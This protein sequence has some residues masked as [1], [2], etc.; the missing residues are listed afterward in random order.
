MRMY[1]LFLFPPFEEGHLM[2]PYYHL[3]MTYI[4]LPVARKHVFKIVYKFIQQRNSVSA[5]EMKIST[6]NRK[7]EYVYFQSLLK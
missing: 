4:I 3:V 5:T 1:N 6:V 7:Q 2:C